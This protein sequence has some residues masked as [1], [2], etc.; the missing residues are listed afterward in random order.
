MLMQIAFCVSSQTTYPIRTIYKGDTVNMF[1]DKQTKDI[2]KLCIEKEACTM[3]LN[4]YKALVLLGDSMLVL[5]EARVRNRED[6]I[7]DKNI[8]IGNKDK[9]IRIITRKSIYNKWLFAGVGVLT[10]AIIVGVIK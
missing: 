6:V 4:E 2:A 5:S 8:I 7:K 9:E 1:T 3:L 10:G